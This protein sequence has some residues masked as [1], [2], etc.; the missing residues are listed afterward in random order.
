M[1]AGPG[2]AGVD[3]RGTGIVVGPAVV[4]LQ[5]VLDG[6]TAT[7]SSVAVAGGV[8]IAIGGGAGV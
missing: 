2:G 4:V 3:V 5:G 7:G 1:G 8:A 6:M